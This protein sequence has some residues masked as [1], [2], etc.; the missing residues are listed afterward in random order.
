[1]LGWTIYTC[2]PGY[3][4]TLSS[5][6]NVGVDGVDDSLE[7]AEVHWER[8]GGGQEVA[9]LSALAPPRVLAPY[10]NYTHWQAPRQ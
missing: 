2:M 10:K 3:S 7:T 5:P 9:H 6:K 1:M 8:K 4:L